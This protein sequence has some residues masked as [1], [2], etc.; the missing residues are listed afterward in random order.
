M[1]DIII[2]LKQTIPEESINVT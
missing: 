2:L 1:F